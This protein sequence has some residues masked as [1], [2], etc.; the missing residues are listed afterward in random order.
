MSI[1][2]EEPLNIFL[3]QE[4]LWMVTKSVGTANYDFDFE[5]LFRCE[6]KW[7]LPKSLTAVA[8]VGA[9]DDYEVFYNGLRQEGVSLIHSPSD[10]L[11][12]S[13][14][15]HWYPLISD[16]TPR[17]IW[18][19]EMPDIE[20]IVQ[21]FEWPIFIKGSR[22]T[23]KHQKSLSIIESLEAFAHV[24]E[25]YA[26]DPILHWQGVVCR[27][28]VELRSIPGGDDN[29]IP[30]SFEFRTFWWKGELVGAGHYWFEGER[31]VWT[32]Q[33]QR[34]ALEI[35]EEVARRVKVPFLVVDV[36]QRVDGKWIVIECNDGQECGYAGVSPIALWKNI[37]ALES[38]DIGS[39]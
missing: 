23:S 38:R 24:R 14:L 16:L 4:T 18:F 30:P 32:S 33:E 17:S 13:E 11:L 20:Q 12:C 21:E 34:D 6:H 26:N 5:H 35:A 8:R 29:T 22:Q 2:L 25:Q 28:Y 39:M 9:R 10:H 37:I 7:Q 1:L 3:L 27:E 19:D 31:Y 36:A 15:P